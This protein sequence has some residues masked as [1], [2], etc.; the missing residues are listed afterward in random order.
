MECYSSVAVMLYGP[1]TIGMNLAARCSLPDLYSLRRFAVDMTKRSPI[2]NG[3]ERLR[4]LFAWNAWLIFASRRLSCT[5][6]CVDR[7]F[8]VRQGEGDEGGSGGEQPKAFWTI[9]AE[10]LEVA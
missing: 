8:V 3:N 4:L 1:S 7:M 5:S 2:L 9:D 10:Q 6:D